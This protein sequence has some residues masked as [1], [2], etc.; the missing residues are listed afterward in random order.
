MGKGY[1]NLKVPQLAGDS[2]GVS[3]PFIICEENL[4]LFIIAGL[5]A[6]TTDRGKRKEGVRSSLF[7]STQGVNICEDF[8]R[9]VEIQRKLL[10]FT[11]AR[12]KGDHMPQVWRI[13]KRGKGKIS[14]KGLIGGPCFFTSF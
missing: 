14:T 5:V 7:L 1:T 10:I 4:Y 9:H 13:A 12:T 11:S 8:S 2:K 6:L 3:R